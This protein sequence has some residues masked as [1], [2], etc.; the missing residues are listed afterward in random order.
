MYVRVV[1][2]ADASRQRIE[3]L[4][5]RIEESDGPPPDIPATGIQLLFDESQGTAVVLQF[6][7]S[8]DD[9]RKGDEVFRAMDPAET[10]G[11]RVSVDMCELKLDRHASA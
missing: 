6:F 2:F 10:P 7:A 5:S 8:A 4:V 3:Q 9:M 11:T 1:R